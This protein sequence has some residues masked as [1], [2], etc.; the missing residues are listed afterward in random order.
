MNEGVPT[1]RMHLLPAGHKQPYSKARLMNENFIPIQAILFSRELYE[2]YGGFHEELSALEDWNLW[3]RYAQGGDFIYVPKVTSVYRT[4]WDLTEQNQRQ[5]QLDAAYD[6]VSAKN[7]ADI[8]K[9]ANLERHE[10]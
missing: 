8:S 9:F 3:V 1:E 10:D 5:K 4:P 6:G 7:I 2:K